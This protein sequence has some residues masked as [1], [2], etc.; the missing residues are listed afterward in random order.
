MTRAVGLVRGLLALLLLAGALPAFAQGTTGSINGTISDNTGAVLP[1]VTVTVSGPAI[2]GVQ[3]GTTNEQGQYR[4]PSLPPGTFRVQYELSG[5]ST[6][7]REGIA[8]NIGFTATVNVQLQVASLAETVTVTGASP[9]VDT[10]NTNV[11]TN[12]TLEI[13]KSI[14]NARDLWALIAVAPGTTMSSFDVGG[15]RAGTQTGYSAYG[16]GDQVRVQVD[17]ANAT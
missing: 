15:S 6:V 8:V 11:Q 3:T 1:G 14:P 13:I 17:G 2:M 4:F 16:R 10:Q 12:F 5:F 7:V 9:V